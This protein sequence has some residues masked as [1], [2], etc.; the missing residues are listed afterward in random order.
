MNSEPHI[1]LELMVYV[2]WGHAN[3]LFGRRRWNREFRINMDVT[4]LKLL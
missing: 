3:W 1:F 4:E 2:Y